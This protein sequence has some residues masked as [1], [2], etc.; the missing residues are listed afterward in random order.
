[1]CWRARA[2]VVQREQRESDLRVERSERRAV[3]PTSVPTEPLPG[4]RV[5]ADRQ[6]ALRAHRRLAAAPRRRLLR[7]RL[8]QTSTTGR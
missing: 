5:L 7:R 4:R 2:Q 1:M 3:R 8:P 6:V